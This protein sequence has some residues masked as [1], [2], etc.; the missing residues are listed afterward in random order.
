MRNSI[1]K[2]GMALS[3]VKGLLT[4]YYSINDY[5][6]RPYPAYKSNRTT[7]YAEQHPAESQVME[8]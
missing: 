3:T 6:N 2:S 1:F 7:C 4:K 8:L 5:R